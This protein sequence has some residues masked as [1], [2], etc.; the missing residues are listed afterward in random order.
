MTPL[1]NAGR[2]SDVSTMIS[3]LTSRA[4]RKKKGLNKV[5]FNP[6]LS[7][8]LFLFSVHFRAFVIPKAYTAKVIPIKFNPTWLKCPSLPQG[9]KVW[10]KKLKKKNQVKTNKPEIRWDHW[11]RKIPKSLCLIE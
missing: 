6:L 8:S 1:S 3:K 9:K 4:R 2:H 10:A 11:L 7:H 5:S